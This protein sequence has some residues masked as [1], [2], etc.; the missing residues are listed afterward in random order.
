MK[1]DMMIRNMS[2]TR[3]TRIVTS[4][5]TTKRLNRVS[6]TEGTK[7]QMWCIQP[8]KSSNGKKRMFRGMRK[9]AGTKW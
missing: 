4:G 2:M 7:F 8:N 1:G 9:M 6:K 5:N 3:D